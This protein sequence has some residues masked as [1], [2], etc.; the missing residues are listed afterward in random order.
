MDWIAPVLISVPLA[1]VALYYLLRWICHP[2][3]LGYTQI[4]SSASC[5]IHICEQGETQPPSIGNSVHGLQENKTSPENG[6]NARYPEQQVRRSLRSKPTFVKLLRPLPVKPVCTSNEIKG[7]TGR[8]EQ[9]TIHISK[10]LPQD[11]N[12]PLLADRESEEKGEAQDLCPVCQ[13]PLS[14]SQEQNWS[15]SSYPAVLQSSWLGREQ[16]QTSRAAHP[17][18]SCPQCDRYDSYY[19]ACPC[20]HQTL[21]SLSP[22]AA[23]SNQQVI[24]PDC[25]PLVGTLFILFA[26]LFLTNSSALQV[27]ALVNM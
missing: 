27:L 9:Q 1:W 22:T 16:L 5:Q 14:N 3:R 25:W 6:A 7:K 17:A 18:P 2:Q 26:I 20:P 8:Q 19:E 11:Q 21:S 10:E 24:C 15:G 23:D 12:V 13:L 4:V